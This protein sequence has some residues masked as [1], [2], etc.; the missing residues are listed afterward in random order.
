[1]LEI[2]NVSKRF[3]IS[4]YWIISLKRLKKGKVIAVNPGHRERKSTLLR[5]INV[6]E[7]PEEGTIQSG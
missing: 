6:L 7:R 5:C 3:E 2:K 1:M 4:R